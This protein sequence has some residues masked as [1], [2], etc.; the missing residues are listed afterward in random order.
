MAWHGL[1]A[2]GKFLF[3]VPVARYARQVLC[4]FF[5]GQTFDPMRLLIKLLRKTNRSDTRPGQGEEGAL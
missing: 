5:S 1:R 4:D 3:N 2:T